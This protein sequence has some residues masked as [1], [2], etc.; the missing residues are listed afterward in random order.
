MA[1]SDI[2]SC[3]LLNININRV[4]FDFSSTA[5]PNNKVEKSQVI[6]WRSKKVQ[7]LK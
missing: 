7:T 5:K 1:E 2:A 4:R 3:K 6:K